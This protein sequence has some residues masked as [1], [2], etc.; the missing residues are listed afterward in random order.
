MYSVDQIGVGQ[1]SEEES[2]RGMVWSSLPLSTLSM[3]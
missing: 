3:P 2:E 1:E